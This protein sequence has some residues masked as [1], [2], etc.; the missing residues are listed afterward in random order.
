M[1]RT[2]TLRPCATSLTPFGGYTGSGSGSHNSPISKVL[3][4]SRGPAAPT[5]RRGRSCAWPAQARSRRRARCP[6][7]SWFTS[8]VHEEVGGWADLL[9]PRL[10]HTVKS[11][12]LPTYQPGSS[13]FVRSCA[14]STCHITS[15]CVASH[16]VACSSQSDGSCHALWL[17]PRG[18]RE[19]VCQWA[20]P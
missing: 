16:H 3:R 13:V 1:Y 4:L 8:R 12:T 14:M 2:L 5:T 10:R 18:R 20:A 9:D 11:L 17:G 19:R 7:P 6:S 15:R